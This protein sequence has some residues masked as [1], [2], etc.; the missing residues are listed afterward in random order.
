MRI[1]NKNIRTEV[2][3][4]IAANGT[5]TLTLSVPPGPS[6][7]I[8]QIGITGNSALEP[9]CSTYV[10]TSSAGV[11]ISNSFTGNGDTDDQPNIT[12]RS[13]DALAAVW[14]G[15]T[16]GARM[17]LTVIYDEVAY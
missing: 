2:S 13:G 1:L 6:R 17:K 3:G 9:T 12:L 14:A 11:F 8:K 10:G 16:S 5:L 15:G 4:N 7:E